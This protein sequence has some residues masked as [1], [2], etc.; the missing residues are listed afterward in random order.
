MSMNFYILKTKR[1]VIRLNPGVFLFST[2]ILALLIFSCS[3]E[4]DAESGSFNFGV[5]KQ[6]ELGKVNKS[7][8]NPLKFRIY[9]INDSR[10]P[11]DVVCVWQGMAEIKIEIETQRT[12]SIVLNTYNNLV[13][14]VAHHI[15]TLK[16]VSPYP[17]STK[18]VA[19]KDYDVSLIITELD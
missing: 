16:E 17:V 15:F 2:L 14:T 9:E 5:E 18:T 4:N 11:S 7:A 19:L 8:T 12:D 6:F 13:D 10:C 3:K 1:I